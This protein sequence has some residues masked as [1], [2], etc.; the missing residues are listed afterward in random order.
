MARLKVDTKSHL[1]E[2]IRECTELDMNADPE[3]GHIRDPVQRALTAKEWLTCRMRQLDNNQQMNIF[4][5][6]RARDAGY[7]P[8]NEFYEARQKY[9]EAFDSLRATAKTNYE[10]AIQTQPALSQ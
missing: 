10:K 6:E 2:I 8:H 3:V 7:L 4:E 5:L 9:L 1:Q